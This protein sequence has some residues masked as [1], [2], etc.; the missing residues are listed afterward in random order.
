MKLFKAPVKNISKLT[1]NV[2]EYDFDYSKDPLDFLPGQFFMIDVLDGNLVKAQRAYSIASSPENKDFFTI[3]IKLIPGGRASS[4]FAGLKIGDE[5]SFIGSYGRFVLQD[6]EKDIVMV[7][8]GTG[9]APFMSMLNVLWSKGFSKPVT[10]Y[11]GVA[12]ETDLFYL[13]ILKKWEEEHD[14]FTFLI[15]LS[16]ESSGW[17]GLKGRVTPH[18]EEALID[19]GNTAIY[20]CGNGNMIK[21]VRDLMLERG[22]PKEDIHFEQFWA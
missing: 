5:C 21:D 6:S 7:A 8:T 16:E 2:Y 22:I 3:C 10:L 1:E 4:Y 18:L 13:D 14:N 15:T 9:I 20:L 12:T 11:F 17:K 19:A